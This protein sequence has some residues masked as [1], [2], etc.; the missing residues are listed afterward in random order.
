M[1]G[2]F[3]AE[4]LLDGRPVDVITAYL[5]YA[6]GHNDPAPLAVNAGKS[7]QGSIV[8]GMGFTFDD[9]DT[10]GVATPIAEM[11]RLIA[12]DPRNGEV[13]FPYIGGQEVNDSPTHAHDR[14]VINFGERDEDECRRRW[15]ALLAIVEEKVRP[16]RDA[17]GDKGAKERWWRFIRPRPDLQTAI[18][19][20]DRVLLIPRVSNTFAF[21]F[22]P[23]RIVCNEKTV[24]FPFANCSPFAVL[25]S[26]VHEGWARFFSSSL[27]DDLQY[28]PSDCF[29]T[30]PF[31]DGW[32]A[33]PTLEAAGQTYFEFRAAL[34]VRNDEGLTNTYNRFQ[35][36]YESD[37]DAATPRPSKQELLSFP[38]VV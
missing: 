31:P 17:Q 37:D 15:P 16:E 34:M 8:L 38:W 5:F 6:G 22:L 11:Q 21:T 2:P 18:A 28:T 14:Y 23:A 32:E 19:G 36:P 29:V 20:L 26:R 10:K 12:A 27:K 25:Q 24:V 7:F 35:D 1:K 30:F 13:I 3:V 33:A 9:T 4:R